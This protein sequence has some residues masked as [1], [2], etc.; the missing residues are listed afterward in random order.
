MKKT[1]IFGHHNPDTDSVCA[2]ICLSYF[3]NIL[4]DNTEPRVLDEINSETKYVLDYF[5]VKKPKLLDN[6]KLQI[7]DVNY[8]KN[9][10]VSSTASI[11]DVYD[12]LSLKKITGVPIVNEEG[13]FEGLI[14]LKIIL[15][16]MIEG[17]LRFI[18]T[19]YD[20]I[21]K[22]LN[23]KKVLKFDEEIKGNIMVGG[24]RTAVFI[25]EVNVSEDNILIITNRPKIINYAINSGI[26]TIIVVG[27]SELDSECKKN[28]KKHNVNIIRTTYDTFYTTKLI[29]WSSYAKNFEDEERIVYFNENDYYNDFIE[30]SKQL[31]HNNYPVVNNKGK[32]LGLLRITDVEDVNK[33]QVILVDHNEE[34]QS[35]SGLYQAEIV[36]IVDHHKIGNF[37]TNI[38]INFRNMAVGST[39]TIIYELY[40]DK[41]ARIPKWVSGLLLSGILSDTLILKSPTTTDIDKKA[42]KELSKLAK[43]DYKKF[44]MSMFKTGFSIK[45]KT[46]IDILETDIKSYELEDNTKYAVS[47]I[48]TLENKEVLDNLD[49]YIEEME[50]LRKQLG[51]KFMVATII[52]VIK[53]G[54][55]F[56]YTEGASDILRMGY[57]LEKM[58]Q[59][60][61]IEGQVSRK[62]QIIPAIINGA[63]KLK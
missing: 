50:N 14:T 42:A 35:V 8:H 37:T 23:G 57:S 13:V 28:A 7:K 4:G 36:E 5:K 49:V 18:N 15:N 43:L 44:G 47:Q 12:F 20:N 53:N 39:C 21:L 56:I 62:K 52:D 19:S 51:C 61:F 33:K 2:S 9:Y 16:K 40:K 34:N 27:S 17:N 41:R 11:R 3:K 48:F 26:K 63:N 38:P 1:Y 22:V 31:K 25:N 55:Y 29:N 54:S 59:G 46:P 60:I 24:Y 6:V 32:C 10:F 45:G 30:T 58:E